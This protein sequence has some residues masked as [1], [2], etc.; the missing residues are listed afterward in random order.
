MFYRHPLDWLNF[1][2][3][4]VR[5][6]LGPYV[7]VF[8]LTQ[9][10]WNQATIGAVLTVSGLI[11]ITLHAP[12]G[13]LIDATHFK[14]GLI[15]AGTCA[16]AVSALAIAWAPTLPVVLTADILMAVAGAIF[17]PTVAAITLGITNQQGLAARL[18]R[19]AAFDRAGNIFIAVLAGVVGWSFSQRAVFY[20]VPLFAILTSLAVLS[21]PSNS[22]DHDRARGLDDNSGTADHRKPAGWHVLVERRP[23]LVL[24]AANALFHF[25]NAPMLLLLGQK[26]A[27]AH[28]GQETALTSACI[29]TAQL[30]TIPTALLVGLKANIWGRKT[31]L[32]VGFA[33]LPIRAVLYT[34]SDNAVWLV[35]VQILDGVAAGTLDALI[36]LVLAD[37]MRGTG[38]YNAARGVLGTVQGVAGSISMTIAGFLVVATGYSATFLALSTVAVGAWLLVLTAMPETG[39]NVLRS[40]VRRSAE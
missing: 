4:D 14:R 30:V 40:G 18:G 5:G 17:A 33:A 20:L 29:I 9:A 38:R 21:I 8:L 39:K 26:L 6:G 13:A 1:F 35:S 10:Q 32:L 16:L 37:I 19:N 11:G 3:A 12:I 2:L 25:A 36:P 15:I 23:L 22:I 24:A 7:G 31:L 28:P 27:L 34:I